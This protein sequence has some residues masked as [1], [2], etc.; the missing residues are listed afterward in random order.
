[1]APF[2]KELSLF[3]AGLNGAKRLVNPLFKELGYTYV[4]EKENIAA[5]NGLLCNDNG[6]KSHLCCTWSHP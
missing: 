6:K 2:E 3:W 5:R 1:M 4:V